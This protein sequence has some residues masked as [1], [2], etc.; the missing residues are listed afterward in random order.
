MRVGILTFQKAIN[1]GAALQAYALQTV[2]EGAG[3]DVTILD[4]SCP[5]LDERQYAQK[6][7]GLKN[8]LRRAAI[9][10]VVGRSL[11][12]KAD[13]FRRFDSQFLNI[14]MPCDRASIQTVAR[15][16]DALVVG[17]DQVWNLSM[18]GHDT[19]YLFDFDAGYT[20]KVSYAASLGQDNIA[21]DD[22]ATIS[23]LISVFDN[24]SV[25]EQSAVE[26]LRA[27]SPGTS[28]ECVLDPTL[29]LPKDEWDP[30]LESVPVPTDP[31]IFVYSLG[32]LEALGKAARA[33]AQAKGLSIICQSPGPRG[34][35]GAKNVHDLGPREFLALLK[36]AEYVIGSSFHGVCL[37]V[38]FEKQFGFVLSSSN[39]RNSRLIDLADMLGVSDRTIDGEEMVPLEPI[40]YSMVWGRLARAREESMRFIERAL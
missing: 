38:V 28:I 29:I 21:E 22:L 6:D 14:G 35:P 39:G 33:V 31:Y 30:I 16:F 10:M 34:I 3:H 36:G 11:M 5:Y 40:D 9:R 15:E 23:R 17:S 13:A 18:T 12:R 24:V 25:R 2:L 4:Y 20:K 26:K 27:A 7:T 32:E 19:G 1:Y 37:S 8:K